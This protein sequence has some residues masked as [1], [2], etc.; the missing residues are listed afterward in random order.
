MKKIVSIV[1]SF[2]L[3]FSLFGCSNNKTTK[4][5]KSFLDLFDTASSITAYDTSQAKF[6]E[7]YNKLYDIIKEY[8]ELYDIYNDYN[9][10]INLKYINENAYKKPIKVDKKI[11]ELLNYGKK[12]Y[13]I[14]DG[15]VNIAMGSVLSIWHDY[16]EKGKSLPPKSLLVSANG[17]TDINNLIIDNKNS[18]VFFKDKKLKLD[19]GAI[20]KGFV[21]NKIYE[22]ITQNNIWQSAVISLGGNII[23]IGNKPD[24]NDFAI[25][26]E[27][28]DSSEFV[29]KVYANDNTSVVTSG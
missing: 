19:V 7:K 17:H 20:T 27:N 11:I 16:R 3:L 15:Y 9:N 24:G 21:C 2:A 18:T 13:K 10:I 29:D 5:S 8:S 22:Y 6:D 28:P 23:T 25:G 4:Y 1:L 26:I 12:A 14:T